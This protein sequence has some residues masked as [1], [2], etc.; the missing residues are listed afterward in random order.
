MWFIF[1]KVIH[2]CTWHI[3]QILPIFLQALPIF[4]NVT[5]FSKCNLFFS[6]CD[7]FF[8]MRPIVPNVTYFSKG[9]LLF[10]VWPIFLRVSP[11]LELWFIFLGVTLCPRIIKIVKQTR[12]LL[13][14]ITHLTTSFLIGRK[15]T[16]KF[17]KSVVV[18]SP[19]WRL[20]TQ[21]SCQG[22]SSSR[23]IISCMTAVPDS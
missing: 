8:Q 14:F 1:S 7:P 6:K 21:R 13:H 2:F 23:V 19:S 9:F 11:F 4:P 22:H 16:V 20:R 15:R 10:Q 17:S 18:T 5:H 3:L 12:E